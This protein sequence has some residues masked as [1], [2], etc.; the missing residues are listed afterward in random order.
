MK[1]RSCPLG[2]V[3]PIAI[4]I[5]V[6]ACGGNSRSGDSENAKGAGAS[7]Q[8]SGAA[9]DGGSNDGQAVSGSGGTPTGGQA[10]TAGGSGAGVPSASGAGGAPMPPRGGTLG[11]AG[12]PGEL[13]TAGDNSSSA[14]SGGKD[15]LSPPAGCMVTSRSSGTNTC[16]LGLRCGGDEFLQASCIDMRIGVWQCECLHGPDPQTYN[17]GGVT[18]LAACRATI[19]LCRSDTPPNPIGPVECPPALEMR[20][21]SACE[22][23]RAC[24]QEIEGFPDATWAVLD[25]T[26]CGDDGTGRLSCSC[27][28]SG[29]SYYLDDHDGTTA[30][31]AIS[32]F[33][34]DPVDPNFETAEWD[35]QPSV[36]SSDSDSCQIRSSC[37]RA[38]AVADGITV[39]QRSWM[40]VACQNS[41]SGSICTCNGAPGEFRI[42]RDEPVSGTASCV[43]LPNFCVG[44]GEVEFSAESS[45]DNVSLTTQ[46]ATCEAQLRCAASAT[47]SGVEVT[48]LRPVSVS[49]TA[50][51]GG[52][53]CTCISDQ[54]S[55]TIPVEG[56]NPWDACTNAS[57][58]C[59]DALVSQQA[60][61]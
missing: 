47:V 26:S 56:A 36:E 34:E 17:L 61:R 7:A 25:E 1:E 38:P 22:I 31:D 27:S 10:I 41:A 45:C 44:L 37:T 29:W 13:P 43:D 3:A 28:N 30:C 21:A 11:V 39:P 49:C 35:C 46:E 6:A 54:A 15:P 19:D 24:T 58:A 8:G 5:L 18:E 53:S 42:E 12:S 14:G 23:R 33:C 60:A 2:G 9:G 50:A 57:E 59:G 40:D 55:T 51:D 4:V 48:T 20:S 52:W 32:E 16:L